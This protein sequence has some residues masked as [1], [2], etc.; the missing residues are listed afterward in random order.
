MK[1]ATCK[2]LAGPC[3][4]EIFGSTPKEMGEN[5]KQHVMDMVKNGDPVH[6]EA[7]E[8]WKTKSPEE[9]QKWFEEFKNGFATLPDA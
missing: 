9:Q 6:Q 1:K 4:A 8:G 2:Q 5:C 3:D 7:V